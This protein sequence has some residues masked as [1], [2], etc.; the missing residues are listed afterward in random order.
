V[1]EILNSPSAVFWIAITLMVI[2]PTIA[3]Y[4]HKSRRDEIE[5]DL[6][7]EMIQRGMSADDIVKVLRA[8]SKGRPVEESPESASS[9]NETAVHQ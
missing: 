6:K 3:Q 8:S 4:W 1:S 7:R 2:V 5:A 9:P